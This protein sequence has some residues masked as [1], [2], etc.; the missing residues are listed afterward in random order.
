MKSFKHIFSYSGV[1]KAEILINII[2]LL[3]LKLINRR[4]VIKTVQSNKMLLDLN[5]PGISKT[6]FL[7]GKR[8]LLETWIVKNEVK[9]DM[10]ILDVGANI[11]YYAL[12]EASL[13]DGGKVYAFEPDSRNMKLLQENIKLNNF[14]NKIEAYPYAVSE[15]NCIRKFHLAQR[16]NLSR[17]VGNNNNNKP[18]NLISV[19]CIRLDEFSNMDK[20]DFIR[21]DI[22]GYE[23]MAIDGMREFLKTTKKPIK[24]MIEVHPN[25][26][27]NDRF[28]FKERMNYLYSL[29]FYI[30]YLISAGVARPKI[31]LDSGYE[32]IK[33]VKEGRLARGLYN[34]V[35]IKDLLNFLDSSTKIVRA[36]F[37]EKKV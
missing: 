7:Y 3:S 13:V 20:I 23:C 22:E 32:P 27:D 6:L 2:K 24:L 11:G 16:R 31:I 34:D 37:F 28:N 5:T 1:S 25:L 9:G 29:D 35:E 26:Y 30:K 19:K 17:I 33:T 15:K 36:I 8:E 14:A 10:N 18:T 21:M 4:Y 12:L